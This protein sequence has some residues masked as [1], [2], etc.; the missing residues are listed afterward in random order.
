MI[1]CV[2]TV[3]GAQRTHHA[4]EKHYA[5]S[6]MYICNVP[7]CCLLVFTVLLTQFLFSILFSLAQLRRSVTRPEA[8]FRRRHVVGVVIS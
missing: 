2:F 4:H 5:R 6:V 3:A 7:E 1:R 8:A